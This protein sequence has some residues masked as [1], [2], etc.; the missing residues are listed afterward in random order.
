MTRPLLLAGLL[1]AFAFNALAADAHA[2]A[3]ALLW[4]KRYDEAKRAYAALLARDARD[5]NAR[6]GLATAE[7]WSGDYRGALS[8]FERLLA[9]RDD[10]DA[11]KAVRDIRA[12]MRPVIDAQTAYVSDEQPF[13][14]AR[15]DARYTFFSDP[16]TTWTAIAG[17][18]RGDVD[19]PFAGAG[20]ESVVGRYRFGASLRLIRFGDDV[21]RAL[22]GASVARPLARGTLRLDLDRHE[23]LDTLAAAATHATATTISMSW[24]SAQSAAAIHRTMYFDRNSGVGADA[25]H[26][27]PISENVQVG[28]S[29]AYGDTDE[30]RFVAGRYQP[31]WT[32]QQLVETRAIVAASRPLGRAT[33]HLHVDG[34]VAHDELLGYGR[35]FHPW[36]LA[37]DVTAPLARGYSVTASAERQ[38]TVFYRA[39]SFRIGIS[40]RL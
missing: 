29:V 26:L 36:R 30:S 18:Y 25:W 3:Q 22:G 39:N 12:T 28:A 38:S 4:A 15:I 2:T 5:A 37:A 24:Q 23:L 8:D 1:V 31:Y 19:A 40:G 14:R 9:L 33:L 34:G 16:L 11:R 7:Y 21:A 27:V 35:T 20:G 6:K 17:S 13:H 10:A 32:P